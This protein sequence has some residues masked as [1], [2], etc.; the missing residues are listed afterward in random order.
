M[1]GVGV[2]NAICIK[3]TVVAIIMD[4]CRDSFVRLYKKASTIL[5]SHGGFLITAVNPW[6]HKVDGGIQIEL[7]EA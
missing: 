3:M 2:D 5:V 6:R 7:Y 1:P 4:E